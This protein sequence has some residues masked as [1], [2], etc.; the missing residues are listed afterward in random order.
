MIRLPESRYTSALDGLKKVTAN[1]LFA[2]S[3]IEGHVGGD[4]YADDASNPSVFHVVHP[5]GMALLFGDISDE[6]LKTGLK[7]FL[8]DPG[9]DQRTGKWLQVFPPALESRFD[10][11]FGDRLKAPGSAEC[12]D[13][14]KKII[15]KH[16]RINFKFNPEKYMNFRRG[17]E[18]D[19]Y[20]F[21]DV[22]ESLF[23]ETGGS[24]VPRRFWNNA[25]DFIA[26]G[27]GFSLI[28]DDRPVSVAFSSFVHD[29]LLELGMETAKEYRRKGYAAITCARLI[30]H[31]RENGIEPVWA[32]S[33]GNISS[34]E[35][36][37]KL[38]F[39]PAASLPYYE[40]GN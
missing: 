8:L 15:I 16:R 35:L 11:I 39:E 10:E 6:F 37:V 38:G 17:L 22:D 20:R 5:Y 21:R 25:R 29:D 2:R 27:V 33:R 12:E 32:C 31:C 7:H 9:D 40:F 13:N 28:V 4:V 26:N 14:G 36:A 34:Y 23:N 24:V 1:N 30:D 19:K 18:I 3:V